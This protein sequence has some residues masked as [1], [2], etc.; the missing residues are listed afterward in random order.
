A[1]L[2]A[3]INFFDTADIYGQGQ[4]EEFLGKAIKG[5]R[6]QVIIATKFGNLLEGQGKGAHPNYIRLAV[7]TSLRRLDTDVIDLYQI[8]TP[9]LEVPIVDTLGALNDLVKAGK[10]REIGC[11]N[12]SAQQLRDAEDA[13][14]KSGWARFVSVQNHYSLVHREPETDGVLAESEKLHQGFLP[15]FPLAS[16]LLTGKYRLGQ[17]VPDGTRLTGRPDA[18]SDEKLVVVEALIQFAEAHGHTILQLA[19]SWLLAKPVVS[20][21]IA[22]ATKPEQVHANVGGAGWN[23]SASDLAEI[24]SILAKA[25]S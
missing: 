16:G 25:V 7:E 1:A 4:S 11:S 14:A 6:D 10:V 23:L 2:D 22:G 8:H 21:V 12:F 15:Y 3:G 5:R 24:D 13:S 18:T 19:F 17:P 20:S 9:D